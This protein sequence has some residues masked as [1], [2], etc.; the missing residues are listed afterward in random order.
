MVS[1]SIRQLTLLILMCI[2]AAG[3]T[4]LAGGKNKPKSQPPPRL[5]ITKAVADVDAAVVYIEGKN[6]GDSPGVLLGTSE[7]EMHEQSVIDS[8][9]T[10]IEAALTTTD[11]GTY[12][13]LVYSGPARTQGFSMDLTIGAVGPQGPEGPG[14]PEGGQGP[15]GQQGPIGPQGPVG[16]PGDFGNVELPLVDATTGETVGSIRVNL[17]GTPTPG[18]SLWIKV[19]QT[20]PQGTKLL[21]SSKDTD[22]VLR[23]D[24]QTGSFIDTFV[25]SGSGGV[26]GPRGVSFGP[27]GHLYVASRSHEV[28]RYD[29]QTGAFLNVFVTQGSGGLSEPRDLLF[30]SDGHLYVTSAATNEV[31]RY[32]GHTGAFLG[33]FAS[34]GSMAWPFGLDFGPDGNLYVTGWSSNDITRFDGTTGNFIDTFAS[35]GEL[36]SAKDLEFGPDGNL[37]VCSDGNDQILRFDGTTGAFIDIFVSS[38]N[39]GLTNP[40]GLKFGPNG[41]LYVSSSNTHQV[42]RYDGQTGA[43]IGTFAAG[44]G[45]SSPTFLVFTP[46]E[47]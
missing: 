29:G 38:G 15:E 26:F 21:V 28:L 47:P 17:T 4:T 35:G 41:S 12:L 7:G 40:V 39:G 6:F 9:D 43:L 30:G 2:F 5:V 44:G 19:P 14:G 36:S 34:G 32:D 45:L 46:P 16:P 1:K 18:T 8:S 24:G 25:S 42:I 20:Q 22:Q 3:Q 27:D 13:L 10:Y 33:V 37:F 23:Y 31:L 11:P